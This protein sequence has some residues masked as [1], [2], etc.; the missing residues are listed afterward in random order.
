MNPLYGPAGIELLAGGVAPAEVIARLID[1]DEG[2]SQ[3]QLHL[4]GAAG[5]GAAHTGSDCVDWCGHHVGSDFS[6][7]GNMLAGPQVLEA[8]VE[9]FLGSA[10]CAARRAAAQRR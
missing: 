3:R 4:I 2:R 6:V 8:T 10:G 1:A 9:A 7:A 5:H